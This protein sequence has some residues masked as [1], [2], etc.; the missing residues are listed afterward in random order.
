[1]MTWLLIGMVV[2]AGSVGDILVS[3]GMK[4]IG[5]V[6]SFNFWFL[7][8]TARKG[9]T[10]LSL[11]GGIGGMAV[12]FFSLLTVLTWAP[13]SLVEPATALCYVFNTFGARLYLNEKVDRMRWAGT[14][15][16]CVGAVLLSVG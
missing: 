5:E 15:L 16:V 14:L 11:L 12:A 1:M 10:N 6:H 3:R 4:Q 9:L 2:C 8:Q 13:V 7:L